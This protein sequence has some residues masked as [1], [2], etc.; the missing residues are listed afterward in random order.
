MKIHP[1]SSD[2]EEC[3]ELLEWKGRSVPLLPPP[4]FTGRRKI[5]QC[6]YHEKCKYPNRTAVHHVEPLCS[7]GLGNDISLPVIS[8]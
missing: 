3:M 7:S 4:P 8:F 5:A 2:K 6:I 1:T